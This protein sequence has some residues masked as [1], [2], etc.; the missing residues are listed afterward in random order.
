MA[1]AGSIMYSRTDVDL[2]KATTINSLMRE[3]SP[4][5]CLV[6]YELDQGCTI[7]YLLPV[8]W[9]HVIYSFPIC[10]V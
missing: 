1:T 8:F 2:T 4:F 3:F 10:F 9:L 6:R 7:D 5:C